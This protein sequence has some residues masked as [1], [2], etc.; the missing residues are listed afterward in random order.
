MPKGDDNLSVHFTPVKF[1][2]FS[3]Y[4]KDYIIIYYLSLTQKK[5]K[6]KYIYIYI[7]W[8]RER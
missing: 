1:R 5:K 3:F 7:Y 4:E 2:F 6:K 8:E